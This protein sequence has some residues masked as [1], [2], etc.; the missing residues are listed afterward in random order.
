MVVAR[1][2]YRRRDS[3]PRATAAELRLAARG[4]TTPIRINAVIVKIGIEI[5]SYKQESSAGSPKE[6][7]EQER[8]RF[9]DGLKHLDTDS[10]LASLR[11]GNWYDRCPLRNWQA[12]DNKGRCLSA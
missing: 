10:L 5:P 2:P 8:E 7:F 6:R 9:Y 1:N 12:G 11:V 4:G 3:R